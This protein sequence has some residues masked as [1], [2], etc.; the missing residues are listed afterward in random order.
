MFQ[1]WTGFLQL[2][3][4]EA[5]FMVLGGAMLDVPTQRWPRWDI[6]ARSNPLGPSSVVVAIGWEAAARRRRS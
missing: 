6:G 1:P 2:E 5:F 4:Y 3:C